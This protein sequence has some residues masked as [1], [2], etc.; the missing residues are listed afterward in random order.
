MRITAELVNAVLAKS[1]TE[2]LGKTL[3]YLQ[4][5][6]AKVQ[7]TNRRAEQANR[8]YVR[9]I[10]ELERQEAALQKTCPHPLMEHHVGACGGN[11][12]HF[13]CAVCGLVEDHDRGG[14]DG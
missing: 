3:E 6:H 14:Y 12:S 11:G 10:D 2:N 5:V 4:E 13:E 9:V 8:E 7:A 1:G